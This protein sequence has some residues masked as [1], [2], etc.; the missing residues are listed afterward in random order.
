MYIKKLKISNFRC[1]KQYDI[2]FAPEVTVLFGKNGSGK[3]TLIHA[4]HKALGFIMYS[5]NIY[6]TV[7][8]ND[9]RK[10]VRKVVDVKTITNNNPYLHP[11]GYAKDDFNNHSDKFIEIEAWADFDDTLHDVHWKMSA[12]ANKCKLRP[13]EFKYAFRDFYNWHTTTNKLP[14]LVYI[15]DSF[16]HREDNK[17]CVIVSKIRELRNFGYFDWDE[18]EGCTNEWVFRLETNLKQQVQILAKGIVSNHHGM[19]VKAEIKKEDEQDFELL[20]KE[21]K[22][23]ENCFKTF[24]DAALFTGNG[25]IQVSALALGKE[26][27]NTGK[28]CVQTTDNREIPFLKLPAGYKRLFN[29]VLDIAYRS[30]ILSERSTTNTPGIA[31]VDEIDLHLH[32]ELE[33]VVLPQLRHTFPNIQLIVSTHS[34]LVLSGVCTSNGSNKILKMEPDNSMPIE[35]FDIYGLD[36]NSGMQLV[37]DVNPNDDELNRLISRC[38]YMIDNGLTE[39][40]NNLKKSIVNK[41]LLS[42]EAVKERINKSRGIH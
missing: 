39:Q 19:P 4:L 24:T 31:I 37:M 22:A 2:N 10:R 6:E 9:K 13:A 5:E 32:P 38:A 23:I 16:P 12:L 26:N 8:G 17:K 20:F 30:Y 3:T 36:L 11:K 27:G 40:A 41:G 15:S 33:K 28:L 35:I 34:P 21:Y 18:E 29:I 42:D 1:F 14:L 25:N 7:K